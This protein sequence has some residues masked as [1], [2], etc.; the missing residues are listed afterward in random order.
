MTQKVNLILLRC[1]LGA[2]LV[3]FLMP[4]TRRSDIMGTSMTISGIES[5]LGLKSS[6]QISYKIKDHQ[7]AFGITKA[8]LGATIAAIA[9]L[10]ALVLTF[11]KGYMGR[12]LSCLSSIACA[13]SLLIMKFKMD[14]NIIKNSDG[15][16]TIQW[17][18]GF[19]LAFLAAILAVVMVLLK[20]PIK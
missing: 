18:W 12:I 5:A 20:K 16:I 13:V 17:L 2:V 19:W 9:A 4:F 10:L 3:L 8:E 11:Y 14:Q 15:L 7:V 1:I 6:V